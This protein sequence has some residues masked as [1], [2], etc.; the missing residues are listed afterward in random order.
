MFVHASTQG[1][2]LRSVSALAMVS[3]AVCAL[4]LVG[5]GQ[6][7]ALYMPGS[8]PPQSKHAHFILGSDT[9]SSSTTVTAPKI[10]PSTNPAGTARPYVPGPIS[11]EIRDDPTQGSSSGSVTVGPAVGSAS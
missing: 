8:T 1:P 11:G 5:C 4:A 3:L 10:K 6:R 9:P 7:G 2:V